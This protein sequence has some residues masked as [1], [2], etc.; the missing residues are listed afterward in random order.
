[1]VLSDLTEDRYY[2][3]IVLPFNSEGEGP[4]SPPV[5][6]YVGEAVPTGE[7]QH[8][9]AES[10]SST[11][12]HLRWKPPQANMQNGDLLGYKVIIFLTS[13]YI[14]NELIALLYIDIFFTL[15]EIRF[16]NRLL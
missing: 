11:E 3:I 16:C 4:T 2:E 12:V 5:T 1:M 8:L 13:S 6:V 9:V 15:S 7:P 14:S 10:I